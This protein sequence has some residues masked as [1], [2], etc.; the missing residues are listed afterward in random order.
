MVLSPTCTKPVLNAVFLDK[1]VDEKCT[2]FFDSMKSRIA[3]LESEQS[4]SK[5]SV[6]ILENTVAQNN[7]TVNYYTET[8]DSFTLE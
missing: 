1:N 2:L 5:N 8:L 7:S 4:S 6:K 3:N